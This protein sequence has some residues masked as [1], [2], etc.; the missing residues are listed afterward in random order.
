MTSETKKIIKIFCE[1]F[2]IKKMF[3]LKDI[4]TRFCGI[5]L[6]VIQYIWSFYTS[7]AG[8]F[9][10][11]ILILCRQENV[12][13]EFHNRWHSAES[14]LCAMCDGAESELFAMLHSAERGVGKK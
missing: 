5:I 1:A 4:L 10:F 12:W 14:E 11:Q 6:G 2:L 8:S 3:C 13:L 9:A 7:G